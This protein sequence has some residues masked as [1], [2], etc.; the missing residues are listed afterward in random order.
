MSDDEELIELYAEMY[1]LTEPE[2]ACSCKIPRSC[3]SSEYCFSAISWAKDQW[4]VDLQPTGHDTLP[5]MG[6]DGCVADPHL[7]PQCTL[8]T[9]DIS[10]LGFKRN[11]LAWTDRYY[12][13]RDKINE[14]EWA[15]E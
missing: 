8:H 5:L 2:C 9:C 7:R 4:G 10:S 3:C 6:P 15:R 13:L 14:M 1:R 11:D 12:K